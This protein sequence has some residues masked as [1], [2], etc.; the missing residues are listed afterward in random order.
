VTLYDWATKLPIAKQTEGHAAGGFDTGGVTT[1]GKIEFS[2]NR[3]G[4]EVLDP[5][6]GRLLVTVA[7]NSRR[8]PDGAWVVEFPNAIYADP[9]REVIVKNGTT[10]ELA[11]KLEL[12]IADEGELEQ[13]VWAQSAFC[14]NSRRFVAATS[15]VVQV[16][17]IPS[18]KKIADF[19]NRTW[20]DPH[21]ADSYPV[22]AVA[23][24]SDGKRVAIRSGTRL[25]L[26]NL[27]WPT[28]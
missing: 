9:P 11:G 16:F 24:T 10:G 8:S 15:N 21:A 1:D 27:K 26:H 3:M 23:C 13:W 19:P 18:G 7:P 20:Q 4:G 14:G 12:Q 2:N 6:T 28:T 22:A 17:A 25:T 5:T